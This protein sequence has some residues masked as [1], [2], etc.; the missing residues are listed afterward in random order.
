MQEILE[1]LKETAIDSI[2]LLPFLFITYLI[3]EYIEHKTSNKVKQVIQKSGKFGPLLG[4]IVGIV[5]QCGFSVSATN[6]YSARVIT[7]GTLI[8]VYLT[9][10]DEMLPIL[11]SETMPASTIL[12]IL[13]IK[14]VIGVLAGFIIDFV[15][16]KLH[17]EKEETKIEEICEHEHCHCEKG[18]LI[19]S[20][21]HTLNIVLFLF[22]TTLIINI[23]FHYVGEDYLSKILLKGTILGPFITSLIGLIPNCGASII[24]TELYLNNA[25]SLSS[26]IAGLLTGSGTALIVLFKENKNIKENIFIICLLYSLGVISGLILELLNIII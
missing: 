10:S 26:L 11:I 17:K 7:L 24:L 18:I 22:I 21:K 1:V 20:I 9:T 16:R 19:S 2:K 15:A 5:P 6:L 8:S 3:M 4:G 23:V 25:I 13:G 14:L 12:T